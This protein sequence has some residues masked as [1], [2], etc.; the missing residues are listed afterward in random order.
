MSLTVVIP[1]WNRRDL[2]EKVL[3]N[4]ANQTARPDEVIVVDNGSTD[5]SPLLA[6][7]LGATVIGFD[8]NR[9]F[10]AAA[11][12]GVAAARSDLVAIVNNDVRLAPTYLGLL[13]AALDENGTSFACGK[14]WSDDAPGQLD[15]T[16]DAVSRGGTAWRCGAGR[17]DG[18]VWNQARQAV[19]P[20]FTAVLLRREYF[21]EVGG[22][23]EAFG[24]YLEDVDFGL[25]SASKGY[26]GRYVPEAEAWHA[27]SATLGRWNPRTVR[28]ISRNQV[29]LLARHYPRNLLV[30]FGWQ[31]A[32]AQ[33]LWGLVALRYGAGSAWVAG[34]ADG[35]LMWT[36]IRRNG[37]PEVASILGSSERLIEDLQRETGFDPYWRIYFALT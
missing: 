12:A 11:N 7:K 23:D 24:S 1:N 36:S 10:S 37:A 34:K 6:E 3:L 9:G 22:L 16:F 20:P 30:R 35:L 5:G 4:L 25:R 13:E 14:L 8:S 17:Q 2:L 31:I 26:T 18:P 29:Y 21:L 33:L 27:G 28:Y 15:G 32:I 19:F